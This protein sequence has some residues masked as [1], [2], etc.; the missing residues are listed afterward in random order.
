MP[1][2]KSSLID[3][4]S[5][6]RSTLR[7]ALAVSHDLAQKFAGPIGENA[8]SPMPAQEN[9]TDIVSDISSLSARLARTLEDHH[10]FVGQFSPSIQSAG[11]V[12]A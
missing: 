3:S 10:A 6:I 11:R 5:E 12:R 8:S 7:G 9:V 2:T 4:L 1:E